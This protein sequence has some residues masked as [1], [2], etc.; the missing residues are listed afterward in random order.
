MEIWDENYEDEAQYELIEVQVEHPP[1]YIEFVE[2]FFKHN[3]K[4]YK[5]K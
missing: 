3:G 2:C 4:L 1:S 5:M